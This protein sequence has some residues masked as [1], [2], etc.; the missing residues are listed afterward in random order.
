MDQVW[1]WLPAAAGVVVAICFVFSLRAGRRQLL[2]DN[3]PT[4][5]TAGV[6]MGLVELEGTAES[7]APMKSHLAGVPCVYY[8]YTVRERTTTT[9]TE[10]YTDSDGRSQSRTVTKTEWETVAQGAVDTVPFELKD[11]RGTIRIQPKGAQVELQTILNR[12]CGPSDPLYDQAYARELPDSDRIRE[13]KEEAIRLHARIVV[14]GNARQRRDIVAAEIAADASAPMFLISTRKEE[15]ISRGLRW[16]F[17]LLGLAGMAMTALGVYL[18][19]QDLH[20]TQAPVVAHLVRAGALYGFAWLAG[21]I[22]MLFNSLID[23][24]QRVNRAWANI[25]VELKRRSDLLPT[26]LKL[27]NGLLEHERI[28]QPLLTA[29]R[30]QGGATAPG[31]PGPDPAA[32]SNPVRIVAEAYPQLKA[33][34]PFAK[35]QRE[36]AQTEERIALARGYFNDIATFYNTRLAVVPDGLLAGLAGMRAR[37]LMDA[38]GFERSAAL[39]KARPAFVGPCPKCQANVY[40]REALNFCPFCA[41]QPVEA[42]TEKTPPHCL[43]CRAYMKPFSPTDGRLAGTVH[44]CG[45][46]GFKLVP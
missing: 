34:A 24:R 16:Q 40:S 26:L 8:R 45:G 28:V 11:D 25:D 14:V 21:W 42:A 37:K 15:S 36:L 23:L 1:H 19:D 7:D 35:L 12:K 43:A 30:A 44:F 4:S 2:I 17:W 5:K 46:C 18:R 13:F 41:G 22:V 3:L 9:E 33:Q 20:P 31:R 39:V 38:A 6:F 27:V 29:M 32:L 10:S